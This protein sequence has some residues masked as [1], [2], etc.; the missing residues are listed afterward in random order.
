[1]N[2]WPWKQNQCFSNRGIKIAVDWFLQ[3]GHPSVKVFVPEHRKEAKGR[4]RD[5]DILHELSDQGIAF[6][7]PSTENCRGSRVTCYDDRF[8]LKCASEDKAVVLSNDK[9]KD[10]INEDAGFRETIRHRLLTYMFA[11]DKFIPAD[12]P[13]GRKGPTLEQFLRNDA[14]DTKTGSCPYGR[15]CTYGSKCR[16]SHPER[17]ES[18]ILDEV[19]IV[20]RQREISASTVTENNNIQFSSQAQ[21]LF[22]TSE[23]WLARFSNHPSVTQ[24]H[25]PL[26]S[27]SA[28]DSLSEQ[29]P[30][31]QKQVGPQRVPLKRESSCTYPSTTHTVIHNRPHSLPPTTLPRDSLPYFQESSRNI[32]I[33]PMPPNQHSMNIQMASLRIPGIP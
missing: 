22:N 30:R 17:E 24:N 20:T 5:V 26:L 13:M 12:D 9:Y 21:P 3:R 14:L 33:N 19:S 15:K 25:L 1:M 32:G 2:A 7:T 10:L 28:G 31:V 29:I 18:A 6:F 8:I 27:R 11:G 4:N 16:Y 23:P